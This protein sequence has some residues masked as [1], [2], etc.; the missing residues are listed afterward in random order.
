MGYTLHIGNA[1][2]AEPDPDDDAFRWEIAPL[3]AIVPEA[4]R[5]PNDTNPGAPFRW[6]SYSAWADFCDA[7]GLRDL[8]YNRESGLLRSHPGI[9]RLNAGHR[10]TIDAALTRYRERHPD[11]VAQFTG[12]S[13]FPPFEAPSPGDMANAHLARLEWLAFWVGWAL[14][15][16]ERPALYNS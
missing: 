2:P 14:D 5:A 9:V 11:A 12:A 15:N 16:C 10:A 1:I 3:S 7:V 6:P 4:P 13:L 8:F